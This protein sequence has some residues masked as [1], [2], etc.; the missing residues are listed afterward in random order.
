MPT[1]DPPLPV[2][3]HAAFSGR[4]ILLTGAT[5][6]LG[7]VWLGLMM[8]KVPGWRQVDV[9]V[10]GSSDR[11]VTQ[12]W[13]K[14]VAHHPLF[15]TLRSTLGNAAFEA[16]LDR[17]HPV[18]G[19]VSRPGFDLSP[20]A[21]KAFLEDT[22]LLLHSAGQV[23]F[24]PPVQ[25]ALLSNTRA[26][27]H[28]AELVESSSRARLLHVSTCY[29]AGRSTGRQQEVS[30][31]RTH[32]PLGDTPVDS[33]LEE[34]DE[35]LDLLRT[36]FD[37][38]F[39]EEEML[40][41][42]SRRHARRG[43]PLP[44][45]DSS[46]WQTMRARGWRDLC[47]AEGER[48]ARAHGH[49]NP[50][51]WSKALAERALEERLEPAQ[52]CIFRPAIVESARHFPLAGWNEG[53]NTSGPLIELIGTA[54]RHLPAHSDH[55]FDVVPVDD[56][57]LGMTTSAAALLQGNAPEIVQCATSD[58]NL[59]TIGRACELTSLG[60]RKHRA[61]GPKPWLRHLET[62]P[63]SPKSAVTPGA[64]AKRLRSA[65]EQLQNAAT[66]LQ[67]PSAGDHAPW[68]SRLLTEGSERLM[69][70]G[71]ALH[72]LNRLLS[73]YAPFLHET[74]QT[75][76]AEA[77]RRLAPHPE[78]F[79]FDPESISW[80]N[81]WMDVHMPGVQRWCQR[82]A[83]TAKPEARPEHPRAGAA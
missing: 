75:F 41:R 81:Y 46:A 17:V 34:V 64:I 14:L 35:R 31:T 66:H 71:R 36:V 1:P 6:F 8:A 20:M 29:V 79:T 56:V 22:D 62:M 38:P 78:A 58:R 9:L 32:P 2:D 67:G 48:L 23:D 63:V 27:I 30:V 39:G 45:R 69:K 57:C 26:A 37:S 33:A 21:R 5:G 54:F 49:P 53:F 3:I 13:E 19:D 55:P 12:R 43:I 83:E 77:L 60:H 74:P 42:E 16:A 25:D 18:R 70:G 10:R 82:S 80:R 52:R 28:A 73:M 40:A 61:N 72:R 47:I 4:R 65:A 15:D 7:K 24:F 59:F 50:Y 11:E 76:E 68:T 51:T 44:D